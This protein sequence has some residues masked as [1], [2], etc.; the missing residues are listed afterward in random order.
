MER[1]NGVIGGMMREIII[2]DVHGCAVELDM[3]LDRVDPRPEDHI[4]FVGDLIHRGPDS[5]RVVRRA[6]RLRAT[7]KVTLVMGN[8]E[9]KAARYR[10]RLAQGT[11]DK[12]TVNEFYVELEKTLSPEDI[13]FLESAVLTCKTRDT[14]L[15]VHAGVLPSTEIPDDLTTLSRK[16]YRKLEGH[17]THLRYCRY[18][19][20]KEKWKSVN[21]NDEQPE[22]QF[23]ADIYDRRFG[24]IT[25]G[26]NPYIGS[27]EPKHFEN[28]TGLDLGC[29]FG[30][31]LAA[32]VTEYEEDGWTVKDFRFEIVEALATYSDAWLSDKG[33]ESRPRI[34]GDE[35]S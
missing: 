1:V 24:H 3:M 35:P 6:R 7:N 15:V 17:L 23:W 13:T 19:K 4:I 8:H 30:G 12:M 11:A 27:P 16:E 21:L 31:R 26:H 25:F 18:D 29:V 28:A 2:G 10:K 22:D 32:V 5:A 14:G 9:E 20:E 34:K 33:G